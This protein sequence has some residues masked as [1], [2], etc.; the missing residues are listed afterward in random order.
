MRAYSVDLRERIVE[1]VKS[2]GM[3]KPAIAELYRISRATVYR[4]LELDRQG[5]L[6]PKPHPGQAPHLDLKGCELLLEQVKNNADF[7]LEEH[8]EK[9]TQQGISL[10]KSAVGNYFAR[11]G[12]RRKK[13]ASA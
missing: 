12:V 3:S 6:V 4:Y 2:R 5:E 13:D 9:L 8:A 7:T 10:K 11:L 1:A